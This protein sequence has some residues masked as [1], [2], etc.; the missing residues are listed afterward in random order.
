[1]DPIMEYDHDEGTAVV[2]GFVYHGTLLPQLIGKYVFGDFSNGP[3][4][5]PGNGRLFYADLN[6]GAIN[7]FI[8]GSDDHPLG[9]WLKGF[10]E[11]ANGEL[12]VLGS[13]NLG[14]SGTTGVVLEMVPEPSSLG[15]LSLAALSLLR[16][17]R[18]SA[19]TI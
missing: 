14:P 12:Y 9:L 6:T 8:L 4:T 10:G 19:T 3:F 7:E 16:R 15:L 5:S 2:G 11:D 18:A 17:R 13:T 1:I